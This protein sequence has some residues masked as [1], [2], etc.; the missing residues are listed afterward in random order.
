MELKDYYAIMGVK[1]TD[2]LKT[3]K[4][5]YRRLARK[6]HPDVSKEPDAEARFKEVAEAWEVLSD[7][8]RR[9]EYDQM[10]QHRNDPQFNRQFHHSDGQSFNAEDFDD[11][12]SSI[13]GQHARQSRQRPATRGH[14][15]EIEVAVFLEETLTEHKRTISYNLP[16]YNAFGMIEQGNSENAECQDPGGRRQ[17]STHPSE[18]PGD[19]GRKR[20]SKW[21]FVAGDSY[22]ATSAVRYCR[23]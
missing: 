8:Q 11:I 12:F 15:I 5:A 17:W 10:W 23:P 1:P 4:T 21:R 2:D 22:C 16:V 3:I 14:D 13:F 7:E 6:Y 9:A 18:R 19:A 20:R